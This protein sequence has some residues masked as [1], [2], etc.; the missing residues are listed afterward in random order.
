MPGL[1]ERTGGEDGSTQDPLEHTRASWEASMLAQLDTLRTS[2]RLEPPSRIAWRCGAALREMSL[3]LAYWGEGVTVEWPALIP[4][5]PDGN[6]HSTF[7][8]AMVLYYLSRADGETPAGKW[9]GFRELPGGGFYHQAFQG[10]TGDQICRGFEAAPAALGQSAAAIGGWPVADLGEYAY[11]FQPFP[12]IRLAA[13]LWL[14]DEEIPSR[15]VVLFDEVASHHLPT[16][17]LALLGSGLTRRL[18]A[19]AERDQARPSRQP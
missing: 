14:G 10:Y 13:V 19:H 15:A 4:L 5:H 2:L 3:E 8:S 9:I 11:A 1:I 7:D 6:P 16:D 12:L 17:G 18:L